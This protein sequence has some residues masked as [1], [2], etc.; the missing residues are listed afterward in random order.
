MISKNKIVVPVVVGLLSLTNGTQ[1][2]GHESF[3]K[4]NNP[5]CNTLALELR[6]EKSFEDLEGK[7]RNINKIEAELLPSDEELLLGCLTELGRQW[8][9][10]QGVMYFGV[11]S[12]ESPSNSQIFYRPENSDLSFYYI[13]R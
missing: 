8:P 11:T 2:L 7:L 10:G 9:Q 12:E 6:P 1:A 13:L 5:T 4:V 3:Q